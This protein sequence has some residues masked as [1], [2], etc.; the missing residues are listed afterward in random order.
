MGTPNADGASAIKMTPEL[1]AKIATAPDNQA[2]KT[3]M[4]EAAIA[5]GLIQKDPYDSDGRNYFG[6]TP[7]EAPIPQGFAKTVIINGQKHFLE[8]ATE[9]A[10][11]HAELEL[12]RS[13]FSKPADNSQQRDSA[14]RLV[15]QK[16]VRHRLLLDA[17]AARGCGAM[18]VDPAAEAQR[19][20][21]VDP[22]AEAEA[23]IVRRAA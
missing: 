6:Y 16:P 14:G 17:E 10:L 4:H 7:V 13:L 15:P 11:Q 5:Q 23:A 21:S 3:L 19:L 18:M 9:D 8:G 12:M 22:A 2:I 20:A 1:E